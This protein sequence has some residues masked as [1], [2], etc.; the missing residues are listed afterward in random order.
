[1]LILTRRKDETIL[2]GKDIKIFVLK[3]NRRETQIGIQA[4]SN[5]KISREDASKPDSLDK[6]T[7]L[8]PTKKVNS[9]EVLSS[10]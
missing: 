4:P 8:P 10:Y 3:T 1:M 5:L 6:K 9:N 7:S 2:I